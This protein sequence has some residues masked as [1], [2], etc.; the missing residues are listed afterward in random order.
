[1]N[2]VMNHAPGAEL[3]ARPVWP[4]VQHA[5]PV[6]QTPPLAKE[7]LKYQGASVAQW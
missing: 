2:F 4:A 7:M 1:M 3:F 5:T 6:L